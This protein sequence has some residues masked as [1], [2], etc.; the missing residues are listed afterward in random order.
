MGVPQT[1]PLH[2]FS[3][4]F[5][6]KLGGGGGGG[7]SSYNFKDFRVLKIVGVSQP[8]PLHGFSPNFQDLELSRFWGA[9]R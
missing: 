1:K 5:Q 2:E 3:P 7:L 9:I 4:N 6:G 8:K